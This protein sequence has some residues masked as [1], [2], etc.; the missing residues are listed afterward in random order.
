[1]ARQLHHRVLAAL[2]QA[3]SL[4]LTAVQQYLTHA[5]LLE[6]WGDPLTADRFRQETVEEMRHSER[7]IQRMV[8]LGL[9]PA[10]SQLQPVATA[11][12]LRGLLEVNTLLEDQLVRHYAEAQ[13]FCQLVG[14]AEQAAFFSELLGEE[15]AHAQALAQ[16]LRE[17]NGPGVNSIH[18]PDLRPPARAA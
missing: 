7:I 6:A 11:T 10:A 15:T 9:A 3:L 1:M 17:L 12:D 5:A 2:G 18:S 13:R 8:S 14:D 4:E 16:W